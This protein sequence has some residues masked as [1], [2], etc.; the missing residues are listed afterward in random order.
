MIRIVRRT[1]GGAVGERR[2]FVSG[3]CPSGGLWL[4]GPQTVRYVARVLRAGPGEAFQGFDSQGTRWSLEWISESDGFRVL[5][6][7]APSEGSPLTLALA[8]GLPKGPKFDGILRQCTEAGVRSFF[9]ILSDRSVVRLTEAERE[10]KRQRWDK[11]LQEASRQCGRSEVPFLSAPLTWEEWLETQ[12]GFELVL[13]PDP[14]APVGLREVLKSH[15]NCRRAALMIG[16][17]GGWSDREKTGATALG[18]VLVKLPTPVLRTETA[19]L[20]AVSMLQF[21]YHP[22]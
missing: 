12:I 3:E 21:H 10:P 9:P 11:I 14:G 15:G 20:A 17:E 7:E 6:T 18:A 13:V 2:V 5:G 8:Q 4:P 19:P 22:S 1:E 16:P